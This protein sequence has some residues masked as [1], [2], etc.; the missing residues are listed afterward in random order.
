MAAEEARQEEEP[1]LDAVAVQVLEAVPSHGNHVLRS[2]KRRNESGKRQK[3]RVWPKHRPTDTL[4]SPP[5]RHYLSA[6]LVLRRRDERRRMIVDALPEI[7]RYR[8]CYGSCELFKKLFSSFSNSQQACAINISD[9]RTILSRLRF[10]AI[11]WLMD[12]L[13][14]FS[15]PLSGRHPGSPANN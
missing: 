4:S 10:A 1:P 6:S 9:R 5:P 3:E 15:L 7:R 8:S 2:P 11:G 12:A 13:F 14:V